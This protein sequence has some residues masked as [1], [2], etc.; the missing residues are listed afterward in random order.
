MRSACA[1]RRMGFEF[2]MKGEAM[3]ENKNNQTQ[4]GK[5]RAI[6]EYSKLVER[7]APKSDM[8]QGLWRAFITGGAICVLGQIITD[9]FAYGFKWGMQSAATAT[10]ICLIFLS[11]LLT[12]LGV[13]DRIGKYAGAGSIVPITGF[14]NSVVAPAMEFRREG[15]VM[16][17]GAK[18][19]TLAGPVL[20]YGIGS[21]ILV[22]LICFFWG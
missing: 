16:G 3:M 11:A 2:A 22:G 12:G 18:M 7:L 19:F 1:G 5:Q 20:V 13:Y 21:S 10:S 17:V 6:E 8:A 9:F 14:A 15:L 4:T